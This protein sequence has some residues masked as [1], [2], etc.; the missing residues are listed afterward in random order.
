MS[1]EPHI[2]TAAGCQ[3]DS[4]RRLVG[5][6][7]DST[8]PRPASGSNPWLVAV[9]CSEHALRAFGHAVRELPSCT[10]V[11]CIW[12]A[13]STGS[14]RKRRRRI[15]RTGHG[16]PPHGRAP[17]LTRI[18]SRGACTWRWAMPPIGLG[19]WLSGFTATVSSSAAAVSGSPRACFSTRLP[20]NSC[21]L[22]GHP[23]RWYPESRG[24]AGAAL[25]SPFLTSGD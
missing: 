13:F 6:V 10:P 22:A 21:T 4:D 1:S 5:L 18:A 3:R 24:P 7:F 15:W 17:C 25:C 19:S 11:P 23:W 8:P 12:S 16:L 14:A 9:D 2:P 20:T